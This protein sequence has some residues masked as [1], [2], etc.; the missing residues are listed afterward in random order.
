LHHRVD[1]ESAFKSNPLVNKWFVLFVQPNLLGTT[2]LG[3]IVSKRVVSK[4]VSRNLI[5]RLVREEFRRQDWKQSN[6][7]VIRLRKN[8]RAEEKLEFRQS[9]A[10]LFSKVKMRY[11]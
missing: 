11:I 4:A 8:V 9:L 5:K 10:N 6:N 1:F 3:I 2:C 7:L